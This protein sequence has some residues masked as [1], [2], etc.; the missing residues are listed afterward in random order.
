[1]SSLNTHLPGLHD[2]SQ[3]RSPPLL[4]IDNIAMEA[5]DR[6]G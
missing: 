4:L 3:G 2:E 6:H 5:F 1:M